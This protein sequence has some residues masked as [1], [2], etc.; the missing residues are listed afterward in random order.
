LV[1]ERVRVGLVGLVV[2]VVVMMMVVAELCSMI[3]LFLIIIVFFFILIVIVL[4][5]FYILI[6]ILIPLVVGVGHQ[7][8]V[9]PREGGRRA[10]LSGGVPDAV[11]AASGQVGPAVAS[12]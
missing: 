5:V 9:I 8:V 10:R 7:C 6:L 2:V 1:S 12:G 4:L 3:F 11:V